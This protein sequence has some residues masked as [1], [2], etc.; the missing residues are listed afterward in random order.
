MSFNRIRYFLQSGYF[1]KIEIEEP[2]NW[3]SDDKELMRS[4]KNEG[5]IKS[6]SGEMQFHGYGSEQ[7]KTAY[8][9][10][11]IKA[12]VK[13]IR[14]YRNDLTD[15]WEVDYSGWFDFSTYKENTK[16][17]GLKVYED[18]FFKQIESNFKTKFELN[19]T[20]DVNGN[21]IGELAFDEI[22]LTGRE[23]DRNTEFT[24]NFALN[25][26]DIEAFTVGVFYPPLKRDFVSNP[27]IQQ[28]LFTKNNANEVSDSLIQ[29][30]AFAEFIITPTLS[31]MIYQPQTDR[32]NVNIILNGLVRHRNFG[33]LFTNFE[34]IT[35]NM[36]KFMFDG[37]NFTAIE[38]LFTT[39]LQTSSVG[40][41][42]INLNVN[43]NNV[44]EVGE[45][46]A[47]YY[48]ISCRNTLP[49][50][51]CTWEVLFDNVKLELKE[52]TFSK[53][54]NCK[55]LTANNAINR[56]TQ[57][58]TGKNSYLSNV[59]NDFW[60]DLYITN[61]FL[62]RQIPDKTITLSLE[63]I[64]TGLNCIDD[65][66][67]TI[68]NEIIRVELLNF[69]YDNSSFIDIGKLANIE[70]ELISDLHYSKIK[71]GFDFNGEYEEVIGLDEFNIEN[72]YTTPIDVQENEIDLVSKVLADSYGIT[73][74]QLKPF[75]T[76]PKLD[77]KY[78]KEN[79]FLDCKSDK[80]VRL[81]QDDFENA[82]TGIFSPNTAFNLRL[83]PVNSLLRKGCSVS[84][85]FQKYQNENIRYSSTE[86]NSQLVTIYAERINEP[87][88]IFAKPYILPELITGVCEMSF[89]KFSEIIRNKY[90]MIKFDN[91]FGFVKSIKLNGNTANIVLI[92][93]NR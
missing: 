45:C 6:L 81:W 61:G 88:S 30:N 3:N 29:T 46:I 14:E 84:V 22:E 82:P 92:K 51:F 74:A 1:G 93:A 50:T 90:K 32:G 66:V 25:R 36:T 86:G 69:V 11:G 71:I 35:F 75:E 47:F 72:Q 83:S 39:G 44:L 91:E 34:Q 53:T 65:I 87:V 67:W 42:N 49:T 38:T 4:D 9:I 64:L 20:T 31:K 78:D 85:G 55:A 56:L 41:N 33:G 16:I 13:I 54:S 18:R 26:V 79:Y 19:R 2:L 5:I 10:D 7:L 80:T 21:P 48:A 60:K 68:E 28:F 52:V 58:I 24:Q 43:I 62:I 40:F 76:N 77:T 70:R 57:I 12:I 8:S 27:L 23:I 73:L 17:V 63:D 15:I 59:L 89:N 37:T